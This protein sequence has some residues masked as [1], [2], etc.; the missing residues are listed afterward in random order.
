MVNLF[1]QTVH[2][3]RRLIELPS[4]VVRE[5]TTRLS[6]AAQNGHFI[7]SPLSK[8]VIFN[9]FACCWVAFWALAAGA[10]CALLAGA[11]FCGWAVAG[12]WFCAFGATKDLVTT[13]PI[14]PNLPTGW[15]LNVISIAPALPTVISIWLLPFQFKLLP[16]LQFQKEQRYH[17]LLLQSNNLH[18]IQLLLQRHLQLELEQVVELVALVVV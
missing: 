5:S 2:S 13:A 7:I 16:F 9:Y 14:S 8:S 17:Q 4:S 11:G 15:L 18:W 10:F 12:C 6:G 1:P 3:R